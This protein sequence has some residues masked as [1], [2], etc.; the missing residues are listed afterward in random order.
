MYAPDP[1]ERSVWFVELALYIRGRGLSAPK[2][3]ENELEHGLI[4][5]EDLGEEQ[6]F[7]IL[8]GIDPEKEWLLYREAT[9]V[10]IDL[11]G[12]ADARFAARRTDRAL[13]ERADDH[14]GHDILEWHWPEL[15]AGP[16]SEE[17]PIVSKRSGGKCCQRPL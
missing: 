1:S 12:E 14:R 13:F 16:A 11:H 10:L 9:R 5:L 8:S 4:L 7:R 3:Y 17:W 6:F 2:I 15:G